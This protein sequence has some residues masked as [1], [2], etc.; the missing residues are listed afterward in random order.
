[1]K[2]FFFFFGLFHAEPFLSASSPV[3]RGESRRTFRKI[4][5]SPETAGAQGPASSALSWFIALFLFSSP[6]ARLLLDRF[7][8]TTEKEKHRKKVTGR[9]EWLPKAQ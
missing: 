8:T 1:M 9:K 3:D 7:I 4:G 6:T 2:L 5:V